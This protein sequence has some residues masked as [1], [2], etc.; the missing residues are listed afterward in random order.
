MPSW[1]VPLI[2][3]GFSASLSNFG[4]AVGLGV[5]PL[6]RGRRIEITLTFLLME[7]LMP[8]LGIILGD[9]LA[10]GIGSKGEVVAGVVLILLGGYT[11]VE[12]RREAR[13]L[14]V[15]ARRRAIWLLA[16]ALS[17]DNLVVGLGLGL[18]HAPLVVAAL[19]MG[20]CSLVL[21]VV[22]LELGR[23]LGERVGERSEIFSGLVLIAAGLFV[24]VRGG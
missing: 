12:T 17:L 4:G 7:I 18:L 10:G 6:T 15:P 9:R 1:V 20:F 11:L 14:Q 8:I 2:F 24:L 5:L 23:L 16:I 22:G 19:F 21:T 3:L 13:D